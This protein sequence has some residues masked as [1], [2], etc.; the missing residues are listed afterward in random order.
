MAENEIIVHECRELH[1]V[2]EQAWASSKTGG[3]EVCGAGII[4]GWILFSIC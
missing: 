4:E 1:R 3:R 2:L